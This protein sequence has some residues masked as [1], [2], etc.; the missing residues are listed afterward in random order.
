MQGHEAD[1]GALLDEAGDVECTRREW[2]GESGGCW[3][4][5][6]R[7]DGTTP[8]PRPASETLSPSL[9]RSRE[10]SANL[11]RLGDSRLEARA[12]GLRTI[13]LQQTNYHLNKSRYMKIK[14]GFARRTDCL[15]IFRIR[16][17]RHEDVYKF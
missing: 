9:Q 15:L 5:G 12:R 17:S 16:I 6:S 4:G 11:S 14:A 8:T 2:H 13:G 1:E 10:P 7:M 3:S